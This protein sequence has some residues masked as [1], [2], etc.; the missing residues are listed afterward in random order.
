MEGIQSSCHEASLVSE[1]QH[2]KSEFQAHP[3]FGAKNE[4][5]PLKPSMLL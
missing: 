5:R 3:S 2:F 1:R 4:N